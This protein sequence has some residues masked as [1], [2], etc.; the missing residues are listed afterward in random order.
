VPGKAAVGCTGFSRAFAVD[1]ADEVI[2]NSL[3]TA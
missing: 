3:K 1:K 2:I